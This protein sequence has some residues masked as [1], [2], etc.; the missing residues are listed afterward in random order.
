[1]ILHVR[2]WE[3]KENWQEDNKVPFSFLIYREEDISSYK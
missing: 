3:N 1:M 2:A